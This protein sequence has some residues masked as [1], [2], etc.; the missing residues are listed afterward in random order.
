MPLFWL[1]LFKY[2]VIQMKPL[3]QAMPLGLDSTL[4]LNQN[5]T[6]MVPGL[7]LVNAATGTATVLTMATVLD[8]Q[9]LGKNWLCPPVVAEMN[10]R[11][12]SVWIGV[13]RQWGFI[14]PCIDFRKSQWPVTQAWDFGTFSG[15]IETVT[16]GTWSLKIWI[17]GQHPNV[18]QYDNKGREIVRWLVSMDLSLMCLLALRFLTE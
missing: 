5:V 8:W 9:V 16:L 10:W 14:T 7:G 3:L 17:S 12:G 18:S 13:P 2:V 11:K 4:W 6:V 15:Q 1:S